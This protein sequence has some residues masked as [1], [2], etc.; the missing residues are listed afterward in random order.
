MH[1]PRCVDSDR[2]SDKGSCSSGCRRLPHT[3][4]HLLR[5]G[6]LLN[7]G[8]RLRRQIGLAG[9]NRCGSTLRRGGPLGFN[10]QQDKER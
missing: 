2:R 4:A 1:E 3:A 10:M 6:N 5:K 8:Q 7:E 9:T